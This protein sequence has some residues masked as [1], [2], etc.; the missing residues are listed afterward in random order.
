MAAWR[1]SEKALE[2]R[3][4][5]AEGPSDRPLVLRAGAEDRAEQVGVVLEGQI[6]GAGRARRRPG[7]RRSPGLHCRRQAPAHGEARW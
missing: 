7:L 6:G 5:G 1:T 3:G 4:Q 2:V